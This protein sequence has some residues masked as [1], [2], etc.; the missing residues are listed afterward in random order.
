MASCRCR[1]RSCPSFRR[2]RRR[3]FDNAHNAQDDIVTNQTIQGQRV[4]AAG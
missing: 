3:R 2:V 4:L 1:V